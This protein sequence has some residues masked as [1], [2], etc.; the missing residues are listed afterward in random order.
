MLV[1]ET[2][3]DALH[4]LRARVPDDPGD[5]EGA[6]VTGLLVAEVQGETPGDQLRRVVGSELG[7]VDVSLVG[8]CGPPSTADVD[9]V[10]LG[11]RSDSRKLQLIAEAIGQKNVTLGGGAFDALVELLFGAAE[12]VDPDPV[13]VV[14]GVNAPELLGAILD[15]RG[16]AWSA[17]R[18]YIE[19]VMGSMAV[20]AANRDNDFEA[21][22][23]RLAPVMLLAALAERQ[24]TPENVALAVDLLGEAVMGAPPEVPETPLEVSHDRTAAER[25]IHYLNTYGDIRQA[26]EEDAFGALARRSAEDYDERRSMLADRYRKEVLAARQQGAHFHLQFVEPQHLEVVVARCRSG[27]GRMA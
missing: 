17:E 1:G 13:W 26:G 7:G 11:H 3:R 27:V 23:P 16:W 22:A 21:L 18:P 5:M 19:N 20:A 10:V 4:A 15:A 2:E 24:G 12:G 9:E 14:L 6:T 25:T 8:A